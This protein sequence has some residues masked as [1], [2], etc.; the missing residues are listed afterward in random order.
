[1]MPYYGSEECY[2]LFEQG[3]CEENEWFVLDSTLN[4][5][6]LPYAHCEKALECE[7]FTLETQNVSSTEYLSKLIFKINL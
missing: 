6:I 3:P 1:M 5:T 2:P 4:D 7:L